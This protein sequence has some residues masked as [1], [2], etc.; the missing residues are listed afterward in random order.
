M[1]NT[2]SCGSDSTGLNP[3]KAG[4]WRLAEVTALGERSLAAAAEHRDGL[5]ELPQSSIRYSPALLF[6]P[7][8][9]S[10]KLSR[11]LGR[12]REKPRIIE[13]HSRDHSLLLLLLLCLF[14]L[15]AL[16]RCRSLAGIPRRVLDRFP[17]SLL[18]RSL[19]HCPNGSPNG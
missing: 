8:K 13:I 12:E 6:F 4:K 14:H 15:V 19:F 1:D 9:R 16:C 3:H 11:A 2:R 10:K 5:E 17:S 18:S 7:H